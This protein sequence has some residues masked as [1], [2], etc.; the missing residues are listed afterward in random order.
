M[1]MPF[2]INFIEDISTNFEDI[3]CGNAI[4]EDTKMI[5]MKKKKEIFRSES[6]LLYIYIPKKRQKLRMIRAGIQF[7]K[8]RGATGSHLDP[9]IK[10][11][12]KAK[13]L[14]IEDRRNMPIF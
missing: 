8:I 4:F 3:S 6:Q 9:S 10:S 12:L 7:W 1:G 11:I 14:F 2:L 5:K 13:F